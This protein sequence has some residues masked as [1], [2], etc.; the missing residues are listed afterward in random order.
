MMVKRQS[1]ITIVAT[2]TLKPEERDFREVELM[3]WLSL[4]WY[5]HLY[6]DF[7]KPPPHRANISWLPLLIDN[8]LTSLMVST[9][10][11]S[12]Y[13][14]SS[15]THMKRHRLFKQR[16]ARI[17]VTPHGWPNF[18]AHSLREASLYARTGIY[19]GLL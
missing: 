4:D 19:K 7:T 13:D 14:T 18:V 5:P 9:S 17:G 16:G 11:N 8:G 2:W 3:A 12:L 10:V 1:F 15:F 6:T